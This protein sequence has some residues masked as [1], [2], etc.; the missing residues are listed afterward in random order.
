MQT[1]NELITLLSAS[2]AAIAQG[3]TSMTMSTPTS[4]GVAAPWVRPSQSLTA[5]FANG[6]KRTVSFTAGSAVADW[7]AGGGGLSSVVAFQGNQYTGQLFVSTKEVWANRSV[8]TTVSWTSFDLGVPLEICVAL[9]NVIN[10]NGHFNIPL[11]AND[12]Y[13]TNFNNVVISGANGFAGLDVAQTATFEISNEIWNNGFS[14]ARAAGYL[15]AN[16]FPGS[17]P[18]GGNYNWNL[19]WRGMR[20]AQMAAL[21]S[22]AWGGSFSRCYPVYGAQ[23]ANTFDFTQGM[24]APYWTSGPPSNYALYPI[25]R[26]A[27]APY[28]GD[29]GLNAADVAK[30]LAQPDGGIT[31]LINTITTN[32]MGGGVTLSSVPASGWMGQITGWMNNYKTSA[33]SYPNI[34]LI[35]YEGGQGF[36]AADA[37]VSGATLTAWATC[38]VNANRDVRMGTA[39]T[40]YLNLWANTMGATAANILHLFQDCGAATNSTGAIQTNA[41]PWGALESIYQTL[42][43]LSNAPQKWQAIRNFIGG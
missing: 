34:K 31:Y 27:I 7:S 30:I 14:Q 25:K 12:A 20:V 43:P 23:A 10:S 35:G 13:I 28:F 32:N 17:A 21:C 24:A 4:N 5:Y 15:G 1:N 9:C 33:A 41:G 38:I 6:D 37:N 39:Y 16:A 40:N 18:G 42:T 19:N 36:F 8:P 26:C 22:T 11:Y 2:S 29:I 3:A